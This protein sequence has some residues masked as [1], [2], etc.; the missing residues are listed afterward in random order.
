MKTKFTVV[1]NYLSPFEEQPDLAGAFVSNERVKAFNQSPTR[2]NLGIGKDSQ[3]TLV[4]LLL[5]R[6][7]VWE[8]APTLVPTVVS[9]TVSGDDE[10]FLALFKA[11]LSDLDAKGHRPLREIPNVWGDKLLREIWDTPEV[12]SLAI[13]KG[14]HYLQGLLGYEGAPLGSWLLTAVAE[15]YTSQLSAE[16]EIAEFGAFLNPIIYDASVPDLPSFPSSPPVAPIAPVADTT[17][18]TWPW[19]A[20]AAVVSFGAL[21]LVGSV[22][23]KGRIR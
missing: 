19:V 14:Y 16:Y 6:K 18:S 23:A 22:V 21:A 4:Y 17:K 9:V 8:A 13:S 11:H 3:L 5:W 2:L 7:R 20:A 15:E 12:Q 1:G 10:Y